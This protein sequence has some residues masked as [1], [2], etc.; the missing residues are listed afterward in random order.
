MLFSENW[1]RELVNPELSRDELIEQLTMA[2]LEVDGFS[3]AANDFNS[4]V[5]GQVVSIEK[6]SDAD[7]LSVCQVKVSEQDSPLQIVCGASNVRAGLKVPVAMI[8][9][10]L[11]KD[12]KIKKSK[13]RGVESNGMLCAAEELGLAE[14]S[15]GLM[16][17]SEDAPLG[18]DIRNY[19]KLDDTII[20]VDL[21]P[22]RGDCLSIKG[23]AREVGALNNCSVKSIQISSVKVTSDQVKQVELLADGACP[24]YVGRVIKGIN[25]NANTPMWMQ[26]KLR[27]GGVR[28]IDPVVDVT[29]YV[30]LEL[31]Q[32]MHAFD[33]DK[34][35]GDIQVRMAK[36]GEKLTLLNNQ[37]IELRDDS[38]VI[39]DSKNALA[40]AGIMGG[41]ESSVTNDSNNIFLESAFFAQLAIAGK[42]RSYGLHTDSSHRF[43][44]GV[45]FE[46]QE[47]AIE[48]A[49]ELLL[50]IVGGEAGPIVHVKSD[51]ALPEV[52][53]VVL[54]KSRITKILGVEIK[55]EK[56][57]AIL[58]GLGFSVR[59]EN[60]QWLVEVP[61]YRFD[62]NIEADLIEEVSRIF[63]Y[64]NL[65]VA[66]LNFSQTLAAKTETVLEKS[67]VLKHLVSLAYQESICYSFIDEKS[68][69][70]FDPNAEIIALA[71]PIS[72]ELAVMRSTLFPGLVKAALF[73]QNR[74]QQAM[75]LFEHGLVFK[76]ING[77]LVQQK[78]LAGLV[79][80]NAMPNAWDGSH[81]LL[82]F[83]D[84]KADIESL[85]K[86]QGHTYRFEA[87]EHHALH[88]GQSAKII[89][90]DQT[91]GY[92]GAL[93]P[94]ISKAMDLDIDVFVFEL[95]LDLLLQNAIPKFTAIS[96]FPGTSRDLA[97]I[98]GKKVTAQAVLD[99]VYQQKSDILK[100]IHIFDL[101]EGDNIG[102]EKK[103]LAI[104][105]FF[106]HA[107]R[108]LEE[109]EVTDFVDKIVKKLEQSFDAK[110]RD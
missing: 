100:N 46:I 11:A 14:S 97:L 27:R 8:G 21:T 78:M 44:R 36:T 30:L 110:L 54:R 9:A 105:I 20:E 96:K 52:K 26:E 103:S 79:S 7:K 81:R 15:S 18:E 63:G 93:H 55:Q 82:D 67:A 90:D 57:E 80:A 23:L 77:E 47:Q 17:L 31:G 64:N 72:A 34:L 71:N 85:L 2:G 39:A 43:E 51:Q 24:R 76:K 28:S 5:V 59:F 98:V 10:K 95:D 45:D 88:P 13:L 48:R 70:L 102:L 58:K 40:L 56:V 35:D 91:L 62:I 16:E 12:F 106:Q 84:V 87:C 1:L 42:A 75:K 101:Y 94:Q 53:S 74:Q 86:A 38:L 4:V 19:L 99:T 3:L 89:K 22:N 41:L 32:P 107:E 83:Y 33:L 49:S 109:L 92:M 6:H 60:E 69:K 73:N 25:P 108:T 50:E 65:P 37:E 104:N 68:Q 66:A 61:S 29:N